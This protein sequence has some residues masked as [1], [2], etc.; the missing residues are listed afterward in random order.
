MCYV[1]LWPVSLELGP[2][3]NFLWN[4]IGNIQISRASLKLGPVNSFMVSKLSNVYATLL[5][6]IF[7]TLI[8]LT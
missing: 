3:N 8:S 5:F 6:M 2:V 4:S 1:E 7:D